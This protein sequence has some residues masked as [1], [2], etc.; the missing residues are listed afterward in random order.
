MGAME[1]LFELFD[2]LTKGEITH[3]E[4]RQKAVPKI[5]IAKSMLRQEEKL[6]KKLESMIRQARKDRQ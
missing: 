5:K 4:Y 6:I 2:K 3:E 1:D